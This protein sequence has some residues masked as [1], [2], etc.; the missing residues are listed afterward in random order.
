MDEQKILQLDGLAL[1]KVARTPQPRFAYATL[2]DTS[3]RPFV[4]LV[5]PRGVGK[6]VLLRQ[7]RSERDTAIY[8][9]ADTLDPDTD[10]FE[11]ARRFSTG[12]GITEFFLDEIHFI[13]DY[14]RYLKQIFDF[15]D[16]R[17]WFTSSVALSLTGAEWD[18]SRRV[19]RMTL[20]PFSFREFLLFRGIAELPPL[21]LDDAL[22]KPVP[23]PHLRTG[24]AFGDYLRGGLYPFM[25]PQGGSLDLFSNMLEKVITQ[26][27]PRFDR[28]MSV[29]DVDDLRKTVEFIGRSAVDG[30]NYST[31]SRNV[32]VTKYKAEKFLEYLE[33]SFLATRV[34]PAGTN[35]LKEPKVLM[36]P[37]YRLLFSLYGEAVG[38]LRE[39]FFLFALATHGRTVHYAKTTRGAKTPD[40]FLPVGGSPTVVEIGGKGKGRS[41]FKELA[42]ER[43]IVLYDGA[44]SDA[45]PGSRVPLF[46]VGFA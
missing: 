6:T 25:L 26:D 30:I 29:K 15:L 12:Y 9:S 38:A 24:S 19:R 41:Q 17:L 5:G 27:I 34:F 45:V 20:L 7:L 23:T 37:P 11:L 21:A 42:Y 16:V 39:E 13:L 44:A 43:K 40:Y 18:L 36:Q 28:E 10:L 3:G 22:T 2:A 33:R 1:E 31:I 8:V 14:Q 4:A 46:C 35:V 32:G